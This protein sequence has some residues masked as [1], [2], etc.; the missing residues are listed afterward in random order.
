[1]NRHVNK[2]AA[3]VALGL[4][5]GLVAIA[6]T[7]TAGAAGELTLVSQ[8]FNLIKDGT[9]RFIVDFPDD[10]ALDGLPNATLVVTAYRAIA[11]REAVTDAL[12]GTL[13]RSADSIDLPLAQLPRTAADSVQGFVQLESTTRT[14]EKLQLSLPGLYPVTLEVRDGNEVIAELITFVYRVPDAADSDSADDLRVALAMR[15]TTPVR[16]TGAGEVIVDDDVITELTQLA[17]LLDVLAPTEVPATI[18]VPPAWLEALATNGQTRLADRLAAGLARH[19]L[20]SAPRLPLDASQAADAGQQALY[21]DWLRDGDDIL[22]AA[23]AKPSVRTVTFIDTPLD[24]GGAALHRDLGS[25]LLVV[26]SDLYD[27]LPGS[28]GTR[29]DTSRLLTVELATDVRLDATVPDRRASA[30]LAATTDPAHTAILLVADLLAARQELIDNDE[31]PSRR[32]ITLATPDLSLPATA[33]LDAIASLLAA[34]P[35][36]VA[37]TLDELALRT[38]E[39]TDDGDLVIVG[40]PATVDGS[41]ALRLT[42]TKSLE[43]EEVAT[44]SML[45]ISDPRPAEWQRMID[46]LPTSALTDAQVTLIIADLQQQFLA[47]RSAVEVPTGYSFT[48][49]GRRTPVRIKLHNTSDTPLTVRVRM[50]SSKLLFPDGDQTVTLPAQAFFDVEIPIEMRSNGRFPVTL[51]V[52]TPAGDDI[53]IAPPVPLTARVTAISGLA[54]LITGAFLLVVITW[55]ARHVRQNR[56]R[57]AA[58]KASLNHPLRGSDGDPL[59][60]DTVDDG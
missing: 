9:F 58:Q 50:T 19:E 4:S 39:L 11:T 57:R 59:S 25:R 32:G 47:I 15:P 6:P 49:T 26:T 33:T 42:P 2:L 13:P 30:L 52:F 45:P 10:L 35:G 12:N 41:L 51:E 38:D 20:L 48:L 34:T 8:D 23:V 56:R 28:L 54:N 37:T 17:D 24:E 60:G 36:L 7:P 27:G 3:A 55:W 43:D 46:L 5:V 21:T 40:L 16:L 1:M 14:P 31:L 44:A 18:S 22:A 53:H 29:A